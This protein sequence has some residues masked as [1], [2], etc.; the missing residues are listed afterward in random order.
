MEQRFHEKDTVYKDII[1]EE[2]NCYRKLNFYCRCFAQDA[3]ILSLFH[4]VLIPQQ[5]WF[6]YS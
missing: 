3:N 2:V 1:V 6:I 4:F 5:F